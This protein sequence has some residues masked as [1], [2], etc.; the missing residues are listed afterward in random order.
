ME[1]CLRLTQKLNLQL[2]NPVKDSYFII[3]IKICLFFCLRHMEKVKK[4]QE[5][6]EQQESKAEFEETPEEPGA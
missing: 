1:Y 6:Q 4:K 5:A 3:I 2:L